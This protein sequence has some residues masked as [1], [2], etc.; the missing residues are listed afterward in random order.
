M[1]IHVRKTPAD[2]ISEKLGDSWA[3]L[4]ERG[5]LSAYKKFP[6][7]SL[8]ICDPLHITYLANAVK[9]QSF[10]KLPLQDKCFLFML[11]TVTWRT[12]GKS[13]L[14]DPEF[15]LLKRHIYAGK[16]LEDLDLGKTPLIHK[17]HV[18]WDAP[19]IAKLYPKAGS[20]PIPSKLSKAEIIHKAQILKRKLKINK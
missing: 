17:L 12:L 4:M 13:L 16:Q 8:Q 7:T 9:D 20:M 3:I 10:Y 11:C 5:I 14:T 15:N 1:K 2:L 6:E 19:E 18:L